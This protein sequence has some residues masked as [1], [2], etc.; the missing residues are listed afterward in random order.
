MT[1][2]LLQV[3]EAFIRTGELADALDMLNQQLNADPGD[4]TARRL[5]AAVLLR[6]PLDGD[7]HLLAAL[8][9]LDALAQPDADDYVQRSIICQR[10]NDWPGALRAMQQAR[11]LKPG[12]ERVAARLLELLLRSGQHDEARALLDTLPRTWRW[13]ERAGDLAAEDGDPAGA[14]QAF[15][16]ALDHLRGQMDTDGNRIGANLKLG[17]LAKRAAAN[18]AAG[19]LDAAEADYALLESLLPGDAAFTFGR[20]LVLARRGD[21]AGG[22]ARCHA[23]LA[24]ANEALRVELWAALAAPEYADL[25]R[26]LNP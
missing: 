3:A 13:L 24:H 1:Y 10:R 8:D 18:L 17:L 4:D 9:D 12:D 25:R 5:R 20:G 6:L 21:S 14:A 16:A 22:A 2:S 11:V 26:L 7:D 19:L 23:A 15:T